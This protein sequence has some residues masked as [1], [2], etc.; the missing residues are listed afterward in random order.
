MKNVDTYFS[1]R[2]DRESLI[3]PQPNALADIFFQLS[4][5]EEKCIK[6]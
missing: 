2:L 4:E 1:Q 5:K 6:Q 3:L